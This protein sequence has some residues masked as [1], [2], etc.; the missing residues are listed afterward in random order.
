MLD[1]NPSFGTDRRF[2]ESALRVAEFL[3]NSTN[4]DLSKIPDSYL[5]GMGFE[6]SD[7]KVSFLDLLNKVS[8]SEGSYEEFTE[9]VNKLIRTD[10]NDWPNKEA[11]IEIQAER[12]LNDPL[13]DFSEF[14]EYDFSQP[15]EMS[16]KMERFLKKVIASIYTD[17]VTSVSD[18][19]GNPPNKENNYLFN[20]EKKSFSGIF[21][22]SAKGDRNKKFSFVISEKSN[23]SWQI[24]Y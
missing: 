7:G 6:Y 21:Y 1:T 19:E 4:G 22:D 18:S 10:Y 17:G 2:S 8:L 23:G 15:G 13:D 11:I 3:W 20:P 14:E 5:A 12:L 16:E 24:S 9:V